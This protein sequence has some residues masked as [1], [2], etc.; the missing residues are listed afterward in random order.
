[1]E[2]DS[3]STGRSRPTANVNSKFERAGCRDVSNPYWIRA[4]CIVPPGEAGLTHARPAFSH[5]ALYTSFDE[6]TP[7]HRWVIL[8]I[9]LRG[10]GRIVVNPS[11]T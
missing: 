2:T 7:F 8:L 5:A 9:H 4:P 1:M 3:S 10:S 6:N 11:L